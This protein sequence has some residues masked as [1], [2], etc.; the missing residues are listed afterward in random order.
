[1]LITVEIKNNRY[2]FTEAVR[3]RFRKR[4]PTSEVVADL[5]QRR[6]H[7]YFRFR[8]LTWHTTVQLNNWLPVFNSCNTNGFLSFV[9]VEAKLNTGFINL[10]HH[11]PR[12]GLAYEVEEKL[13]EIYHVNQTAPCDLLTSTGRLYEFDIRTKN[14]WF[15]HTRQPI[16]QNPVTHEQCYDVAGWEEVNIFSHLKAQTAV[17]INYT[18]PC[19]LPGRCRY[20]MRTFNFI[21]ITCD[22]D[23]RLLNVGYWE[24]G[25]SLQKCSFCKSPIAINW[26]EVPR[27][28]W[29]LEVRFPVPHRFLIEEHLVPH[30]IVVDHVM[31][32][33]V[34]I[35]YQ[36]MQPWAAFSHNCYL[37]T[38]EGEQYSYNDSRDEGAFRKRTRYVP[39][40]ANTYMERAVYVRV[41]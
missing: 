38:I 24:P 37:F 32:R 9:R 40:H 36:V 33:R 11:R 14:I 17:T 39:S 22:S 4:T 16:V 20:Q 25:V 12:D 15:N 31:F 34:Y 41:S 8:G 19:P 7:Q 29:L 30:T 21:E 26:V 1:M 10:F 5:N 2:F 23:I 35:T 13:R 27:T 3:L 18:C 28:T 6:S